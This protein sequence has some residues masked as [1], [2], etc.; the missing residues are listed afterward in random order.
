MKQKYSYYLCGNSNKN[1]AT[2]KFIFIF[3]E[4]EVSYEYSKKDYQTLI[5]ERLII[6]N[7]EIIF[8]NREK[9]TKFKIDMKGAEY[10]QNDVGSSNISIIN[11]VANNSILE[12]NLIN[13][14]FNTFRTFI[15]NMLLFK[16]LDERI[17]LGFE[18]G[19]QYIENYIITQNRLSDFEKLLNNIGIECKLIDRYIDGKMYIFSVFKNIEIRLKYIAS[20]GTEA[21]TAF[22]FWYLKIQ[23]KKASF[24]FIDEF[25]AFYHHDLSTIII[26]KL[27]EITDTQVILTTHNTSNISNDLLRPDCYFIMDNKKIT[28]LKD[29]THKELRE[30]HNIEKMYRA[31]SFE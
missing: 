2:F 9:S 19:A 10:L 8:I 28:S 13:K 1:K 15:N 29:R 17:Y 27:K 26:E 31:G 14:T 6:N 23:E 7:K 4:I 30:A 3:D 21:L 25:D 20:S 5:S 22:Y 16:T 11:Y 24:L 18:Q 12:D